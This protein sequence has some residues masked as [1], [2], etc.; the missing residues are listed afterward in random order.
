MITY[1]APDSVT[2]P[3]KD[4]KRLP[5][6]QQMRPMWEENTSKWKKYLTFTKPRDYM[7]QKD[8]IIYVPYFKAYVL[9]RKNFVHDWA[10]IPAP[11]RI[12]SSADGILAPGSTFHDEG[13]RF[14]GLYISPEKNEPFVFVRISRGELDDAFR[15]H[16]LWHNDLPAIINPA[17]AALRVFGGLNYGQRDIETVDWS[18]PVTSDTGM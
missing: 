17:Y 15:V 16:N 5:D 10:S 11:L 13:Y 1:T 8:W 2:W 14:E 9:I 12:F 18:Q 4:E 6:F 3:E 7:F